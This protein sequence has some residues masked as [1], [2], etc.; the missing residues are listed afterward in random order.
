[1]RSTFSERLV[2]ARAGQM[3]TAFPASRGKVFFFRLMGGAILNTSLPRHVGV[4]T[5]RQA[6]ELAEEA[7][8]LAR[9]GSRCDVF[10]TVGR[11]RGK[12][13]DDIGCGRRL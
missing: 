1:M 10:A 2:R 6:R 3:C 9:G 8:Q 13:S 11:R 4:R 12:D 5:F 7:R